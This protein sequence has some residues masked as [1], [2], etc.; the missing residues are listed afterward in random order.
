MKHY[1]VHVCEENYGVV[2][3]D[4]KNEEEARVKAYQAVGMGEA[5]WNNCE[6]T[7]TAIHEAPELKG[8]PV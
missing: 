4:A 3:V 1:Y 7:I 2:I 6:T 8:R 5:N